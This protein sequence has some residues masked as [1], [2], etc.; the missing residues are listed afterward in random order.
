MTEVPNGKILAAQEL[1]G[2]NVSEFSRDDFIAYYYSLIG[3]SRSVFDEH[4]REARNYLESIDAA[5]ALR[6]LAGISYYEIQHIETMRSE[7]FADFD[8]L[9]EAVTERINKLSIR[10]DSS[11]FDAQFAT[12]MVAWA[13]VQPE[14][15]VS[16]KKSSISEHSRTI[17]V[18]GKTYRVPARG[19]APV[20]RYAWADRMIKPNNK[21]LCEMFLKESEYL[22]RTFKSEQVTQQSL[23]AGV[24]TKLNIAD[25]KRFHYGSVRLSGV[26]SRAMLYEQELGAIKT[27]PRNMSPEDKAVYMEEMGRVFEQKFHNETILKQ[28]LSQYKAYKSFFHKKK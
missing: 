8:D 24:T 12:L 9:F 3:I 21:G 15:A 1:A 5:D 25:G 4:K 6:E 13:G 7:F 11:V 2:K 26:F 28:R 20:V 18:D 27:M 16:I 17:M 10:V 22:F 14:D 23:L 19:M